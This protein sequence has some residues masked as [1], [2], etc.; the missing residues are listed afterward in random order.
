ME[1]I[2][3]IRTI[4]PIKFHVAHHWKLKLLFYIHSKGEDATAERPSSL[5]HEHESRKLRV[6]LRLS[7][8]RII[9]Q[10]AETYHT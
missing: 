6:V 10:Q 3:D 8:L 1:R 4:C 5:T 9:L 7:Q 2:L